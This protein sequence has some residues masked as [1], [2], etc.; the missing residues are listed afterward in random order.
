VSFAFLPAGRTWLADIY[1]DAEPHRVVRR[2]AVVTAESILHFDLRASGGVA[3]RLH[4][5]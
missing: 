1:E 4:A 5:Q 2:N 3:I